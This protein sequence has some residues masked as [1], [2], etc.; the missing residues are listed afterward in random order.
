MRMTK[1]PKEQLDRIADYT[2][3]LNNGVFKFL[4]D[5]AREG[6]PY[7]NA[8]EDIGYNRQ[9]P[10]IKNLSALEKECGIK[11]MSGI[12]KIMAESEPCTVKQKISE[13][14]SILREEYPQFSHY[15]KC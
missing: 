8:Y 2:G 14:H 13:L 12:K 10:D 15:L 5:V 4:D 7:D 11:L 6:R 9:I 3:G 1:Y